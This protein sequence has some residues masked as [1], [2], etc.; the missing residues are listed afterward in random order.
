MKN[1]SG[2]QTKQQRAWEAFMAIVI[3]RGQELRQIRSDIDARVIGNLI[4][5]AFQ[6][7][8]SVPLWL[9]NSICLNN[10]MRLKPFS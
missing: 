6:S 9:L 5:G 1:K 8:K 4:I 10:G 3:Q 7:T 2:K